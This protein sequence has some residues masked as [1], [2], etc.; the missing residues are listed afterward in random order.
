MFS[1]SDYD[2]HLPEHLIAQAPAFARDQSR[3]LCLNR[4]TGGMTH[5]LFSDIIDILT[6][7]DLLVTNNTKVIPARLHGRKESGGKIEL[8]LIDYANPRQHPNSAG[9]LEYECLIKASKSPRPGA[10]LDFGPDL[11][12][13]VTG[14]HDR[15]FSIEFI[16]EKPFDD[17]LDQ[18]G[19][20]PLPPY[21]HRNQTNSSALKDR[22][23]YQ[24]IYAANKGAVA[25]PTAGLH[26]TKSLLEKIRHN[27]IEIVEITLHVGYG[28]F[29]PVKVSD[30]RE[31]RIHSEYY[32]ISDDAAEIITKAK[33]QRRRVVAV[34]TT[35]VRTLEFAAQRHG[36]VTAGSGNCDLFIFPGYQF[37][38][39]DAMITNFHL[40]KS[41][42]LMLVSA[43]AGTENILN[44]YNEAI[45]EKY[46]FYS[47]GD[48]MI[49]E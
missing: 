4:A 41:T 42:L 44:A 6:P 21:I 1:L 27:G 33:A 26:F 46:R 12:A 48:A 24:T 15:T 35:S 43:F 22:E 13:V 8:L 34:G 30:I 16:S 49:I 2:Y 17:I 40:P 3:L 36:A 37:N 20:V 32:T 9:N 14:V 19:E 23:S 29:M 5:H 39:V 38:I 47:Y 10:R 7:S 31:H 11:Q 25:A 18:I 45:K 28:T